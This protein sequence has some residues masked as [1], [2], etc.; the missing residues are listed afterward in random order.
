MVMK[1]LC[2][3][4]EQKHRGERDRGAMRLKMGEKRGPGWPHA[5]DGS[6][7]DV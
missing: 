7:R 4:R 3:R 1:L 6:L 2:M 5:Q